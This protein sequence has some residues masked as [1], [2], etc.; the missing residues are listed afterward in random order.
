[1]KVADPITKAALKVLKNWTTVAEY[2]QHHD[3][4]QRGHTR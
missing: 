3:F 2:D 1:M 4:R